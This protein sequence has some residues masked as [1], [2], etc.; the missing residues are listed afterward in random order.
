L[1]QGDSKGAA[2]QL[3]SSLVKTPYFRT[4]VALTAR[5]VVLGLAGGAGRAG[6]FVPALAS[7][8]EDTV[9][10]ARAG[11]AISQGKTVLLFA[12]DSD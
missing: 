11:R 4:L 12:N 10:L 7:T 3:R 1:L 2:E 9:A 8:D 6:V 5:D